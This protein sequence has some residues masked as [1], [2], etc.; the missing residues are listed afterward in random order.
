MSAD[1]GGRP[2]SRSGRQTAAYLYHVVVEGYTGSVFP[3]SRRVAS[4]RTY[5]STS[6]EEG[7][8][9]DPNAMPLRHS[10]WTAGICRFYSM[11]I[12]VG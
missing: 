3:S 1:F 9:D 2:S 7:R 5:A 12:R 4:S 11:G 8:F 10:V 6:G